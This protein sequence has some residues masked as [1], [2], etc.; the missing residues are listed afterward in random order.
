MPIILIISNG[1]FA[2]KQAVKLVG[3]TESN[4]YYIN[5]TY[6]TADR[7]I[8][9]SIKDPYL[10]F[11]R[12]IQETDVKSRLAFFHLKHEDQ[13]DQSSYEAKLRGLNEL[14]S[15]VGDDPKSHLIIHITD[16]NNIPL[17]LVEKIK[18]VYATYQSSLSSLSVLYNSWLHRQFTN[19][20]D[21]TT[22]LDVLWKD[23][24]CAVISTNPSTL[25]ACGGF[26]Q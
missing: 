1:T 4:V 3:L 24:N 15:L 20:A 21:M 9:I 6:R 2:I 11:S 5:D 18:Y 25:T 12:N 22:A 8:N 14:I 19:V 23:N 16:A 17:Y 26:Q 13:L 10:V 7:A